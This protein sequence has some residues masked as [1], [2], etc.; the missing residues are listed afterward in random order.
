MNVPPRQ[1]Q[2]A[3][4]VTQKAKGMFEDYRK[5]NLK[6]DLNDNELREFAF[7]RA[8]TDYS[9][10]M[11]A[12]VKQLPIT[13]ALSEPSPSIRARTQVITGETIPSVKTEMSQMEEMSFPQKEKFTKDVLKSGAIASIA[14]AL[15]IK[16]RIRVTVAS[17]AYESKVNPNLKV[18]VVNGNSA[19]AEKDARDLAYAMSYVFKQDSTPFFRADPSLLNKDQYGISFKFNRELTI[20]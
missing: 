11:K 6:S 3:S 14:D 1:V 2:A 4:W 9:H 19:T 15:G 13:Q 20:F 17:G 18:Q 8:V 7:E 16:S 5:R 12:K 10:L